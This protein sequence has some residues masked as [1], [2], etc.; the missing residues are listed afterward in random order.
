MCK[1]QNR[2]SDGERKKWLAIY[3]KYFKNCY[4]FWRG[5]NCGKSLSIRKALDELLKVK[6]YPFS[7]NGEPANEEILKEFCQKWESIYNELIDAVRNETYRNIRFCDACGLP[8]EEGYYLAGEYA[9]DKE[10]CLELYHDD[11]Q[12]MEEDLSHAEEDCC[13]TYWTEWNSI[14]FDDWL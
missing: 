13:E 5:V 4:K 7:P 2:T 6:H 11:K 12:E 8:M 3:Y 1:E 14:F 9:C 10:C